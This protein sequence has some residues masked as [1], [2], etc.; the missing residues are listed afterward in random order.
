MKP[1]LAL[2]GVCL[3][4]GLLSSCSMVPANT[5]DLLEP[6]KLSPDQAALAEA[7]ERG[8]GTDD[9]TLKYPISGENRSAYILCNLSPPM[10][11]W[12]STS[13]P[14]PTPSA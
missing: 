2:L 1:V 6:P 9:F 7:L 14:A 4:T 5:E 12:Y 13:S 11:R 8:L 3:L 10:R